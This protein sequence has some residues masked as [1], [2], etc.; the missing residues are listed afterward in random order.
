MTPLLSVS[1]L[2]RRFGGLMAVN[3]VSFDI[4]EGEVVGLLGP[5]G[6]GKTTA[7]NM[8][9][10]AMKP[11]GGEIQLRGEQ[12]GGVSSHRIARKGIARTFQLVRVLPSLTVDENV[13]AALAFRGEPL[14]GDA[15][16]READKLL[17]RVG[18]GG[19]GGE[20]A[21]QLTYIDQKRVELA[22]ALAARPALL[23][24]DEWLAGLNPTELRTGIGLIASLRDT[25]ITIL[26]VEHVMEAV[27]SLCARCVVM[28]AGSKIAD[29][30]TAGVLADPEVVRAY[31][32]T[33]NA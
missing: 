6:S 10:G 22:R 20:A 7:L 2:T 4:A 30:D 18:L 16:R 9:S 11:S 28:N 5:N 3:G 14:W 8:I 31:L 17:H 21:E 15:A 26:L 19:R 29:G 27:R 23:L 12:I 13:V 32:G 1:R 33:G 25:G 24:L